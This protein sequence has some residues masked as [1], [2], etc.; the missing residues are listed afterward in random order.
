MSPEPNDVHIQIWGALLDGI[1][2]DAFLSA[3]N[4]FARNGGTQTP[5]LPQIRQFALRCQGDNTQLTSLEAWEHVWLCMRLPDDHK[6]SE[7]EKKC[8]RAMGGTWTL[9]N[10]TDANRDRRSFCAMYEKIILESP[11]PV[12]QNTDL[13]NHALQAPAKPKEDPIK[14]VN[15][16]E[17]KYYTADETRALCQMVIKNL[18]EKFGH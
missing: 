2:G 7:P 3:V 16:E 11:Q 4:H 18:D 14:I 5:T 6:M 17:S 10:S 15:G 1:E 9:R 13:N 8:V 12:S